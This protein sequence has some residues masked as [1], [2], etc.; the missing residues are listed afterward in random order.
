MAF[1]RN[2]FILTILLALGLGALIY[3]TEYRFAHPLAY[4]M[5]AFFAIITFVTSYVVGKGT[6]SDPQSYQLFFMGSSVFRVLLCMMAVFIYVYLAT[7]RELQFALNFFTFYFIY[8]GFEIYG[9]LS[10]LRQISKKQ[11][12]SGGLES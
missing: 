3:Y 12:P 11:V 1:F 7:D 2:L 10:N 5:L 8:T 6:G 4:Y 9:I